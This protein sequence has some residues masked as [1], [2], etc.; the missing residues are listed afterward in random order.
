MRNLKDIVF[1]KLKISTKKQFLFDDILNAKDK[2]EFSEC[3]I[4][5]RE[6]ISK[7][8]EE[9]ELQYN[10]TNNLYTMKS[11]TYSD[12]RTV[13]INIQD[14]IIH[15]GTANNSFVIWFS[16]LDG[17]FI[18]V[19]YDSHGNRVGMSWFPLLEDELEESKGIFVLP[20]EL[21]SEYEYIKDMAK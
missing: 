9:V 13:Y 19:L 5:L 3:A 4:K 6:H 20:R 11:G 8:A 7:I 1:E 2:T 21:M 18:E 14:T 16:K 12:S 15:I 17:T 10:H